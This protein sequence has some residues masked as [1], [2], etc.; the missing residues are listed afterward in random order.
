LD[1]K[2]DS[3]ECRV[4]RKFTENCLSV[5][6][7]VKRSKA[8]YCHGND[9]DQLPTATASYRCYLQQSKVA[10]NILSFS[11]ERVLS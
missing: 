9:N 3:V 6:S 7:D 1:E 10:M 8:G 2:F 11:R 5:R 4:E